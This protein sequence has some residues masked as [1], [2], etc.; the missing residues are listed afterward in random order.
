[1]VFL[2]PRWV[3]LMTMFASL[4]TSFLVDFATSAVEIWYQQRSWGCRHRIDRSWVNFKQYGFIYIGTADDI[5]W[6]LINPKI[7][8]GMLQSDSYCRCMLFDQRLNIPMPRCDHYGL[9]NFSFWRNP[10]IQNTF[11]F[12]N[13]YVFTRCWC[14]PCRELT[15]PLP[16]QFWRWLSFSP[17][18]ICY[19]VAWRV[20]L[21]DVDV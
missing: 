20:F 19:I 2:R 5:F 21:Q 10:S 18:E 7:A 4:W 11:L 8:T 16:G 14:L 17:G 13:I 1:M 9:A 3:G 6:K 12:R 15:Y